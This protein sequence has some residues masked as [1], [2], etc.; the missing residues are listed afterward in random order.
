MGLAVDRI[1]V[2]VVARPRPRRLRNRGLFP[3]KATDFPPLLS[4][5][6]GCGAQR[7]LYEIRGGSFSCVVPPDLGAKL[8]DESR[9]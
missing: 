7:D 2:C 6:V 4:N 1:S 3:V 8:S 5:K 9:F